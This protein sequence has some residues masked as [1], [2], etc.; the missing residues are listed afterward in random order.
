MVPRQG[1]PRGVHPAAPHLSHLRCP[2]VCTLL[3]R[4]ASGAAEA[5]GAHVCYRCYMGSCLLARF[6][7]PLLTATFARP[8][9][10]CS[11]AIAPSHAIALQWL[12]AWPRSAGSRAARMWATP[13]GWTPREALPAR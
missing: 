8:C 4:C 12:T 13:S 3:L 6:S 1:L 5:L 7:L 10:I 9:H 2:L 11:R